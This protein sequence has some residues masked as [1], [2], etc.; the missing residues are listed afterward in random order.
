MRRK[1]IIELGIVIILV[2]LLF[3]G[4]RSLF[5]QNKGPRSTAPVAEIISETVPSTPRQSSLLEVK[6]RNVKDDN[7]VVRFNAIVDALP[8]GRDPFASKRL[9]AMGSRQTLVLGGIMWDPQKPTVIINRIFLNEGDA[10]G[11]FQV[12]KIQPGSVRL[13]DNVSEFELHLAPHKN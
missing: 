1:D 8:V 4:I 13:K 3:G 7:F 10:L 2:I 9:D 11:E 12:V 5:Q 6:R